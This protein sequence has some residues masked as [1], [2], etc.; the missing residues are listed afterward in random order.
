MR[1]PACAFLIALF[2]GAVFGQQPEAGPR[3]EIA[4]V[5][6][7]PKGRNVFGRGGGAHAGRYEMKSASMVDLIRAAY[8]YPNNRILEG[9]NWIE[10]DRFDVTAKEPTGTTPDAR[11]LMLQALLEDRFKLVVRKEQRP[12]PTY[13]LVA[14]KKPVLKEANGSGDTGCKPKPAPASGP[15]AEGGMLFGINGVRIVLGPGGTIEY[16]CRN[17]SMAEF[18]GGLRNMFGA[19]DLGQNPV[20][21]ETGIKGTWNFDIHFSIGF[22]GL[23]TEARER[24][25]LSEAIERQLGLK[26][27]QRQIPTPVIVVESVNQKPS[28][29]PPGIAEALPPLKTATEFEVADVK[30]SAP[31]GR[32]G[33]GLRD[34]PGGRVSGTVP[35]GLLL[36]RAFNTFNQ[37]ELIGVPDWAN[38]TQFDI[39]AKAPVEAG[40]I[41]L[42]QQ[43]MATMIRSLLA[44][45]FKMTWH[46]EQRPV[47]A[48]T[49]VA[50]KPKMKKADPKVRAS[51]KNVE[52][53]A[54]SPPTTQSLVCQDVTM[55]QFADQLQ[56]MAQGLNW[57][58]TDSTELEGE[59]DFT[60]TYNRNPQMAAMVAGAGR[61]GGD[62]SSTVNVPMASDP[63]GAV[64]IFEALEKQLGLKL[65]PRKVNMPVTVID[66]LEQKPT[67]N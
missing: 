5:H 62:P 40:Q 47:T 61:G 4:D 48:Y 15:P 37:E 10:M 64:T 18:A 25:K 39:V 27:D 66:H 54:G 31:G 16:N 67:D 32:G 60:L 9:P 55:E 63:S 23:A 42:D 45:R 7:S 6:A 20:M 21:D 2:C 49:L 34:Q 52:P 57:P 56:G 51:C 36:I 29:N 24:I 22:I 59:W 8:G 13:A 33:M 46:T 14:G 65:S 11:K 58:V 17:M 41:A 1:Y 43:T 28:E 19:G 44:D 35:M 50:V 26:L 3:F 53:P 12:M 30:P 38:M